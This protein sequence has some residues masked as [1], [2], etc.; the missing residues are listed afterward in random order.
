MD[1]G[2]LTRN[3]SFDVAQVITLPLAGGSDAVAAGEGNALSKRV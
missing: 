1:V 2:Y 3:A